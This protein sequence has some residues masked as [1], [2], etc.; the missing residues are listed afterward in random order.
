MQLFVVRHAIAEDALPGH[1][2]AARELTADGE[3][4]LRRVVQGVRGLGWRF[5]RVLTSPWA[6]AAR[7]AELLAPL[8]D[9]KPVATELLCQ[10]PG[11]ELLALIADV[12]APPHKRS[13]TAVVGH[14]PWLTQLIG[15]LVLG[16]PEAGRAFELKKAGIAWL[17]GNA[18]AGGMT[19][20]ALLAPKLA[21]AMR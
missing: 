1:D 18:A 6:R 7:T 10:A 15:W 8:S 13:G 5:E 11:P 17:E 9:G 19:L 12:T 16:E 4:R 14:E 20:R 2:D 3:R 21:Q